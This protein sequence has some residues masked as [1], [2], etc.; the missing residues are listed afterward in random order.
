MQR[1]PSITSAHR[2]ATAAIA[3]LVIVSGCGG[4]TGSGGAPKNLTPIDAAAGDFVDKTGFDTVDI[5]IKDNEYTPQYVT[6]TAGTTVI[7]TVVGANVHNVS[8]DDNGAFTANREMARGAM[9]TVIF[10]NVGDY[11]YFC[12][13]HGTKKSGQRGGI[14]VVAKK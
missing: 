4:G 13:F 5:S 7:W 9:H 12:S 2:V 1:T 3:L 11:A 10:K 8:P 6:I 14:R